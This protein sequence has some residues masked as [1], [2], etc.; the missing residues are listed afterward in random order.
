MGFTNDTTWNE[1]HERKTGMI[2]SPL[3]ASTGIVTYTA[4]FTVAADNLRVTIGAEWISI[5]EG[6]WS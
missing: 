6:D 4:R 3:G 2:Q 5:P 1:Q